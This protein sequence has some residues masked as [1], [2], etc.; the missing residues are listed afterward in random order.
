MTLGNVMIRKHAVNL[1]KFGFQVINHLSRW[2]KCVTEPQTWSKVATVLASHLRRKSTFQRQLKSLKAWHKIGKNV[3]NLLKLT[4][5][6]TVL[7]ISYAFII[8]L[9][10]I[11]KTW[12]L[13]RFVIFF[14]TSLL[15]LFYFWFGEKKYQNDCS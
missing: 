10:P 1:S 7:F 11:W 8:A 15:T 6:V 3:S 14:L 2:E 12:S 9:L 4:E 13:I 5:K